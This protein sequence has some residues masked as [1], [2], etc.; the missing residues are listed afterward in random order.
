MALKMLKMMQ[1]YQK[2]IFWGFLLFFFAIFSFFWKIIKNMGEKLGS[3][4]VDRYS[5][6]NL[7]LG[8]SW[9]QNA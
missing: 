5:L 9:N 6:P 1:I 7:E 2:Y 3:N 4:K 8:Y